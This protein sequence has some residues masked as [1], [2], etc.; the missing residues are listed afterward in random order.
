MRYL[1]VVFAPW[2]FVI[3]AACA[4]PQIKSTN[5]EMGEF[6]EQVSKEL[7][8]FHYLNSKETEKVGLCLSELE[9]VMLAQVV[10]DGNEGLSLVL[11]NKEEAFG[12]LSSVRSRE[13]TQLRNYTLKLAPD[14]SKKEARDDKE[15]EDSKQSA[16]QM[17]AALFQLKE[18]LLTAKNEYEDPSFGF[19]Q[20]PKEVK[21]KFQF[22]V[23]R[24][25]KDEIGI[26]VLSDALLSQIGFESSSSTS[27][28]NDASATV[29]FGTAPDNGICKNPATK[30][31][32]DSAGSIG[33]SN[34]FNVR[35]I[36]LGG[37]LE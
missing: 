34:I 15:F 20:V 14:Y 9:V 22:K 29:T 36:P 3:V 26:T 6:V 17:G 31:S 10:S 30:G 23:V 7:Q 1:R 24:V 25:S 27:Q 4:P 5:I 19:P 18:S 12:V 13:E 11:G 8:Y 28:T 37:A 33:G 21:A 35:D 32:P 2:S 16:F